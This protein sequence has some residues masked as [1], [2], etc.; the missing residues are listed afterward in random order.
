[1]NPIPLRR[2]IRL[3]L[4]LTLFAG[5]AGCS[6]DQGSGDDA[7]EVAKETPATTEAPPPPAEGAATEPT[8]AHPMAPDF[9]LPTVDGK[10]VK[11]SSLRG[12]VV[13]LDFWA[14]WC[15]PCRKAIPHLNELHG[16]FHERGLEIVGLSLDR[17]GAKDVNAFLQKQKMVYTLAIANR[18]V[19]AS[20]GG[21]RSIPTAFLVD[22]EGRVRQQYVGF[23][24]GS[25]Y[26][27]D[28]LALLEEKT[29]QGDDDTI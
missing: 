5:F 1:M 21:V 20:Y 4:C 2:V 15:G 29:E 12:K 13:L 11:L 16:K 10:T 27:K 8:D 24:P 22:R 19:A 3:V 14:T 17:G 7:A 9:E 25:V 18:E 6:A 23:R 26:E 28:I